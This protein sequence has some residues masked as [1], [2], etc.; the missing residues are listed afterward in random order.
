MGFV[1]IFSDYFAI[2]KMR[3]IIL[4]TIVC[5]PLVTSSPLA[6]GEGFSL[7]SLEN[8]ETHLDNLWTSFKKGYDVIYN[9]TA[10]EIHRFQIFAK[11]VKLILQHNIEHDLGLHTYR[12]GINKYAAMVKERRKQRK[13]VVV[14]F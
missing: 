8:I 13:N 5:I 11:H 7:P 9:T 12:L 6:L 3:L 1:W 14:V 2:D 10:E 4:I